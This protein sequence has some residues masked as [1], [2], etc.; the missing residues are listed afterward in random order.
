MVPERWSQWSRYAEQG[1]LPLLELRRAFQRRHLLAGGK[2]RCA[3]GGRPV[4]T[5]SMSGMWAEL[6]PGRV[7]LTAPMA[8]LIDLCES[9]CF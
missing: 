4:F 2:A 6:L 7:G 1:E 8:T 9:Q 3:T 5:N